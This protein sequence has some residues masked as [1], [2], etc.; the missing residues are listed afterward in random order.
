MSCSHRAVLHHRL[1]EAVRH[2]EASSPL[3]PGRRR[4]A[5]VWASSRPCAATASAPRAL[6]ALPRLSPTPAAQGPRGPERGT[7]VLETCR[8]LQAPRAS[9]IFREVRTKVRRGR[10]AAGGASSPRLRGGSPP[11]L[12]GSRHRLGV[13]G[14]RSDRLR[15]QLSDTG[16]PR[17]SLAQVPAP[18]SPIALAAAPAALDRLLRWAVPPDCYCCFPSGCRRRLPKSARP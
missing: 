11:P 14:K 8:L 10:A 9:V 16:V 6:P 3:R 2:V 4:S 15:P 1:A 18:R 5:T 7:T 12:R 17:G 13:S